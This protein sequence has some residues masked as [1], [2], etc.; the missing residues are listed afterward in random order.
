M[1][2]SKCNLRRYNTDDPEYFDFENLLPNAA[3]GCT[4]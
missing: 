2:L 3:G 4:S 1:C